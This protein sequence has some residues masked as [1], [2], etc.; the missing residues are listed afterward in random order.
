[1]DEISVHIVDPNG[2]ERELKIPTGITMSLME[3]LKAYD[4]PVESTCGGM[5]LCAS[6]LVEILDGLDGTGELTDDEEAMLD[7][8]PEYNENYRLSCQ[9]SV[10]ESLNGLRFRFLDPAT[11]EA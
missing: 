9:V 5:A 7:T 1:M 3:A 10:E 2:T 4:E 6:C 11:M 8:L